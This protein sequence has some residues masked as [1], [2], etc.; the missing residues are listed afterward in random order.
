MT[1]ARV[2]RQAQQIIAA[3]SK[4]FAFASRLLS[5]AQRVAA[6]II[7]SYCRRV[8]DAVDLATPERQRAA[9]DELSRELDLIYGDGADSLDPVPLSPSKGSIIAAFAELSRAHDI[10]RHY[11]A[12]LIAGMEM[13]AGGF[14]Y[15]TWDDLILYCY[16]VAGTVGLMMCHVF[17]VTDERALEHAAH[18]GIAM[19]L[20]NI[21]RDV[22]EDWELGR[23]YLPRT[24]LDGCGLAN[25]HADLGKP[26]PARARTPM[27]A[28]VK[29]T[30]AWADAYYASGDAGL[31]CLPWRSAL[32]VRA[33]RL[34][35]AAIG[36]RIAAQNFDVLAGRAMVPG[37]DKAVLCARAGR[38]AIAELS[39]RI[40]RR[41]AFH[42]P[43]TTLPF[44]ES[45]M[46]RKEAA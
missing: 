31:A 35:Y 39:D 17:G 9:I 34:I 14:R 15:E 7:Y 41:R 23:I 44:S 42:A 18:M 6:T 16:R 30:L 36:D 5:P 46:L 1:S 13:D 38:E 40:R 20:T 28:A 8:D 29:T 21:C 37:K 2:K 19:Q 12:Q 10:P 11:P 26:F 33:A 27:K 25:L 4:S 45:L 32:A 43:K 22:A 24:I 3:K